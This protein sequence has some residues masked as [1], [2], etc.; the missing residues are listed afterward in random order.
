MKSVRISVAVSPKVDAGSIQV[1]I[2]TGTS[3]ATQTNEETGEEEL[4]EVTFRTPSAGASGE[5]TNAFPVGAVLKLEFDAT[6]AKNMTLIMVARA[7]ASAYN[8]GEDFPIDGIMKIELNDVEI[9]LTDVLIPNEKWA[10]NDTI[11]GQVA[12]KAGTNTIKVTALDSMPYL[13]YFQLVPVV[14]SLHPDR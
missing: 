4:I 12:V 2:E 1:E 6:E 7:P 14:Q 11:I 10:F 8:S 3:I 13:D 9:S 5:V